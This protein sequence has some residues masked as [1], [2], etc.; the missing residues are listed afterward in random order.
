MTRKPLR[1]HSQKIQNPQPKK[2]FFECRAED[3][4]NLV[5]VW[6]AL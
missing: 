2:F 5:R 3:L 4:P 1:R 6:T